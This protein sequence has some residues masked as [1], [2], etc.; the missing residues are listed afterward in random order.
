MRIPVTGR[1]PAPSINSAPSYTRRR[2]PLQVSACLD[3]WESSQKWSAAGNATS[4]S[5]MHVFANAASACLPAE[6]GGFFGGA[7]QNGAKLGA[8]LGGAK[9][10]KCNSPRKAYE[11]LA[12]QLLKLR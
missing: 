7:P 6:R 12:N 8:G 4:R 10:Q 2:L 1:Q 3:K 11:M 9:A 5:R